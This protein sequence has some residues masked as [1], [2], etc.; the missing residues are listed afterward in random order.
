MITERIVSSGFNRL[1]VGAV[2]FAPGL[3]RPIETV[4]CELVKRWEIRRLKILQAQS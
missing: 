3:Q 2:G 1:A 4:N